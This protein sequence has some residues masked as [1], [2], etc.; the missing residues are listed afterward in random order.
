M[1]GVHVKQDRESP[2]VVFPISKKGTYYYS[3]CSFLSEAWGNMDDELWVDLLGSSSSSL[4]ESFLISIPKL[5]I[6]SSVMLIISLLLSAE[7]GSASLVRGTWIGEVDVSGLNR[8]SLFFNPYST[9]YKFSGSDML[10]YQLLVPGPIL[11]SDIFSG[12]LS[13]FVLFILSRRS[14]FWD[15]AKLLLDF[16]FFIFSAKICQ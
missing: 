12:S 10:K 6:E 8:P 5:S 2:Q 14:V 3:Y 15:A 11:I 4:P 13:F 1:E 16:S 9:I 7:Y